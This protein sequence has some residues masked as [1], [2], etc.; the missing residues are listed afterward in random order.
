MRQVKAKVLSN[1]QILSYSGAKYFLMRIKA[2]DIARESRPGQFLMVK[3][4]EKVVLRRPLSIHDVT[5]SGEVHLL[6]TIPDSNS[7]EKPPEVGR[8]MEIKSI[9]GQGTLWLSKLEEGVE[10]D[11]LGPLGNGFQIEPSTQNILI[12][13]GGI[14]IAPLKFL[15][16]KALALKKSVTILLG[17]RTRSGIYPENLLPREVKLVLATEDGSLGRKARVTDLL[18]EHLVWA[19][20][21]FAC[22]P[23][24]MYVEMVKQ[25]TDREVKKPVQFSLEVRM[26]CGVGACYACSIKTK[27]GMLR[28]CREGPVFNISD[29]IW[30][31]VKI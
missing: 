29:I 28:V 11:L 22:G 25:C 16:K 24:A 8:E 1:R 30:Q 21:V 9:K 17:A 15:A 20:Q 6:F 10:L 26:G 13:A 7:T 31:E 18:H 5:R 12:V 4:G 3:C 27:Q 19:D 14:G 23:Q 2:P